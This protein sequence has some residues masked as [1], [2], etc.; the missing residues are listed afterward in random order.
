[1][2]PMGVGFIYLKADLMDKI[3]PAFAGYRSVKSSIE[4]LKYKLDFL[5]DAKKFEYASQNYLGICGLWSSLET[6]SKVGPTA[7]E[8]HLLILG[9]H[10]VER[11][12][13]FD[14]QFIGSD[15]PFYWSGIYS[16]KC[17]DAE[18]LLIYL[19][20]KDVICSVISGH[21]RF[22]PHFYNNRDDINETI[23]LIAQWYRTHN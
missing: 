21:L 3:N 9:K 22:S 6:L 12:P 17:P 16:F 2:G 13:D 18:E 10:L 1:M 5:P 11:L 19:K 7:I 15:D 23:E 14:L 20:S 8:Q 4:N